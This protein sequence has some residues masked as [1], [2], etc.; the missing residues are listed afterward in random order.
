M[1]TTIL[2]MPI[3]EAA[4]QPRSAPVPDKQSEALVELLKQPAA[5]PDRPTRVT[6]IETHI[7]W[8]FVADRFVYKLKKPV[9][10][11]FVDFSTPDARRRACLAEC[12]LNRRMAR[13]VYL[14]V[15]PITTDA[16]GTLTLGGQGW[17]VDWVVKMRR[18]PAERMLDGLLRVGQLS[19]ADGERLAAWLANYYDRLSPVCMDAVSYRQAI[20]RHVLGNRAELLDAKHS[21]PIELVKRCHAAQMR[22]LALSHSQVDGRVCDGRIVDGHGDLRPEHICLESEPIVFD[23]LEFNDELRRV[24]VADE[25]AFLA[26]EC[27]G[28]G[29]ERLGRQTLETYQKVSGDRVSPALWNFYKCY[30]ACVRAK[31]AMLAAQQLDASFSNTARRRALE[32][33]TLADRYAREL[34]PPSLMIVCGLMGSGKTTLATVLADRLGSDVLSTDTIRRELLGASPSPSAFNEAHYAPQ[35]RQQVYHEMLRRAGALLKQGVSLVLDGAFLTAAQRRAAVELAETCGAASLLVHCVCPAVVALERIER[36]AAGASLSEA[37]P[38]LYASQQSAQEPL[39]EGRV[40]EVDT[41]SAL[42]V[43]EAAVFEA[44][45]KCLAAR[46]KTSSGGIN[47]G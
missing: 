44:L 15:L 38:E 1:A 31:V 6:L 13:G 2:E 23:C 39:H 26:M 29:A 36:R 35:L 22:F 10:F 43:Q 41:T 42:G 14:G 34:G 19:D 28:L 25:L 11:D 21:L 37:R 27:D 8:V 18:L 20:E 30:R 47:T 4:R 7:S 5:H 46:C 17:V 32:Y 45:E 33:L 40:I 16:R 9:R 3:T 12:D 24:D